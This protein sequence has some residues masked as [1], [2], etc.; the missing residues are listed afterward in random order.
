MRLPEVYLS[1]AEALNELDRGSEAYSYINMV[2]ARVAMPGLK[3]GMDKV[4]LRNAILRENVLEYAY[5]QVR[6]FDLNRWKRSDIWKTTA[7]LT[8]LTITKVGSGF[9]YTKKPTPDPRVSFQN[10]NP[11]L[12]LEPIPVGEINKKYGLI[13]NPGW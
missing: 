7:Q 3:A 13:Q 5:E 10:F 8:G 1:I 2:R 9:T 4:T 11:R 12:Y 6:F